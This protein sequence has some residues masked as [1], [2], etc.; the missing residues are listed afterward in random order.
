M[1]PCKLWATELHLE[2]RLSVRISATE[3]GLELSRSNLN[4]LRRQGKQERERGGAVLHL[5]VGEDGDIKAHQ[6]GE[7]GE[8]G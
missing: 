1:M 6:W 5:C 2:L 8:R 7:E 4:R 3:L